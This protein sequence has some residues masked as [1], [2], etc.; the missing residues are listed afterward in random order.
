[1]GGR[2]ASFYRG[3]FISCVQSTLGDFPSEQRERS[4]S[5]AIPCLPGHCGRLGP[6][7]TTLVPAT[8]A[9]LES[10]HAPL[11]S[12]R[13]P[14]ASVAR[15]TVPVIPATPGGAGDR[16]GPAGGPVSL[17][18]RGRSGLTEAPS[19]RPGASGAPDTGGGGGS[20]GQSRTTS[21]PPLQNRNPGRPAPAGPKKCLTPGGRSPVSRE[22]RREATQ[23]M[24]LPSKEPSHT[25]K[26]WPTW[27]H[28]SLLRQLSSK[29]SCLIHR[30]SPE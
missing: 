1:M 5:K 13:A 29:S 16:C 15:V 23:K 4:W 18:P 21:A 9:L 10:P 2:T 8:I 20:A 14:A 30:A 24:P 25:S 12:L 3:I 6:Q 17:P 27:G 22:D 11:W 19:G 26:G 7:R 28:L